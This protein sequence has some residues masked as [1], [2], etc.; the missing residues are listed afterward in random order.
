MSKAQL[1]I[2]AVLLGT[3]QKRSRPRLRRLPILGPATGP[4]L[5]N[6]GAR[7]VRTTL[8]P[9]PPHSRR[10]RAN[11]H[12]LHSTASRSSTHIELLS[13]P[14]AHAG[15]QISCPR[16]SSDV[17][18]MSH[19]P[20]NRDKSSGAGEQVRW[21]KPTPPNARDW[22]RSAT[23]S[24]PASRKPAA[25]AGSARSTAC[26]SASSA[27]ARNSPPLDHASPRTLSS[28]KP[29][30]YPSPAKC[31]PPAGQALSLI[32]TPQS[33]QFARNPG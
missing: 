32:Y 14:V 12:L 5:R 21:R 6:R 16:L 3:Q 17:P 18:W 20:R 29:L 11:L 28:G 23:T 9:P 26:R 22:S 24:R 30:R 4:T 8:A 33:R 1:V 15:F 2:T 13:T 7:S 10:R 27:P 31:Y 25:K 19:G